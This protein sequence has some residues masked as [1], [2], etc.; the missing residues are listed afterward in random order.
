VLGVGRLVPKKG[1]RHLIEAAALSPGGFEVELAGDGPERPDLER[2]A[3]ARKVEG[4]VIFDGELGE[5][6]L[7]AACA[8]AD[9]ICMPSV[10]A[11]DGDR[12]G[13]PNA[14]L[15]A[16]A[17]SLPAVTTDAGGLPEAAEDG[18]TGL[19]V[20][21]ADAQA[22]AEALERLERDAEL[23]ARL[24]AGAHELLRERFSLERNA[25]RLAGLLR[26]AA[27]PRA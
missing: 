27:G 25:A 5:E 26:A 21:Q 4:R 24:V 19:V 16:M 18:R 1:F 20:P 23:R 6:G 7:A 8:R 22:L 17:A 14:L 3:A 13:V 9:A 12:D 11:S 10:L 15:E 2:L